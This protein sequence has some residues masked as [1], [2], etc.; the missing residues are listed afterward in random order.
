MRAIRVHE[1]GGPEKLQLDEIP[2]PTPAN[3]ELLIDVKAIGLNFIEVYLREGLYPMPRPFIPGTEACGVVA[4]VGPG[5][6]EFK[7]GDVVVSQS[8][9]GS[10]AERTIVP[11]ATAV[12]VP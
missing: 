2:D 10:Y 11:A 12:A 1:T 5:V 9:K 8:V 6:D 4:A 3:G 7:V